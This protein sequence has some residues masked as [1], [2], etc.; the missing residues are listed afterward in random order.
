M[1]ETYPNSGRN[2]PETLNEEANGIFLLPDGIFLMYDGIFLLP[3]GI[4]LLSD[5]IFLLYDGI[6][7]LSDGIFPSRRK[8]FPVAGKISDRR[9]IPLVAGIFCFWPEFFSGH[10]WP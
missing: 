1:S 9:N 4:F 7:L 8:N 6:F 3:D 2:L 10:G 5:G